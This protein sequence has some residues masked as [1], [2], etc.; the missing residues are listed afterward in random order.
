MPEYL[1]TYQDQ[2]LNDHWDTFKAW[3]KLLIPIMLL[4]AGVSTYFGFFFP[5]H[6]PAGVDDQFS[7]SA[8]FKQHERIR[9]SRINNQRN[10]LGMGN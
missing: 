9:K 4:G 3:E 6:H 1:V 8:A 5:S 7:E 2:H 10:F